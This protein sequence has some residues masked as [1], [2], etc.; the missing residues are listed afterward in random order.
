M[1][2]ETLLYVT[3]G[4]T[5]LPLHSVA[6]LTD[7]VK[8]FMGSGH[9]HRYTGLYWKDGGICYTGNQRFFCLLSMQYHD[10]S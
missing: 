3:R 7:S 8:D 6:F 4:T 1:G 2:V 5:D 9:G 10:E